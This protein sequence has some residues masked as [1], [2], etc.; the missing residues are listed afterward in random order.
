MAFVVKDDV[1]VNPI[2]VHFF[3]A[4]AVVLRAQQ[5]VNLIKQLLGLGVI[6]YKM[7]R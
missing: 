2:R 3:R 1:A 5:V 7:S 6:G 4:I